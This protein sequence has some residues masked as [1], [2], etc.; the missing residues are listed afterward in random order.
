MRIHSKN[1]SN[2]FKKVKKKFS[3]KRLL[4]SFIILIGLI[5]FGFANILYGAYLNKTGQTS[6]LRMF[7]IRSYERDFSYIPNTF[8]STV[9]PIEDISIDIKFKNWQKIKFIREKALAGQ[10]IDRQKREEVPAKIR[11]KNDVFKASISIT[12]QTNEHIKHPTRWSF[13]VKIK[14]DKTVNGA[15]KFAIIYPSARGYLTDWTAFKLL[16]SQGL[17]GIKN[18][19]VNVTINGKTIGLYYFEERFGDKLIDN[20]KRPEGFIFRLD[21]D[22][23]VYQANKIQK[24][25]EIAAQLIQLKKLLHLL[26]TDKISIEKVFDLE[27]FATLFVISDIM[28]QKHAL[29]RGNM[30]LYYNPVT[31][32]IEPIGR[33]W[34]YLRA[35]E[36]TELALAIEE[37]NEKV[38]YHIDLHEDPVLSKMMNS[39]IF[40]REYVKKAH[41]LSK[42]NYIDSILNNNKADFD[43][44]MNKIHKQNPF[45][46]YPLDLLHEN[47]EYMRLKL[48]PYPL[49]PRIDVF[50]NNISNDS[51][52]LFVKN[53]TFFNIHIDS[54]EYNQKVFSLEKN[55]LLEANYKTSNNLQRL[56]FHSS[57]SINVSTFSSDSLVVYYNVSGLESVEKAIV[58]PKLMSDNDY[59]EVH[60]TKQSPNFNDFSFLRV[61]NKNKTIT[62]P[63]VNCNIT[64][65]LIVPEDYTLI[66]RAGC[67]IDLTNS[68][69]IIS[70]SPLL[71]FGKENQPIEITSSDKSGQGIIV[72]NSRKNSELSYTN[73]TF[74][75][76]ISNDYW[77]LESPIIFYESPFSLSNCVFKNNISGS[78]YL[79][80]IRTKFNI[81]N[82]AFENLKNGAFSASYA[83]GKL[84]TLRFQAIPKDAINVSDSKLEIIE[85]NITDF[86]GIGINASN[87]SKLICNNITLVG[88]EISVASENNTSIIINGLKISSS[89]LGFKVSQERPGAQPSVIKAIKVNLNNV[90]NEFLV[91]EG[92]LLTIDNRVRR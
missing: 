30:R 31:N 16:E 18:D 60:K 61:D 64:K 85:N 17:I 70:Y 86:K 8:K 1:D 37:P 84:D 44:L 4:L 68:A 48:H 66:A 79:K 71:F 83:E 58:F 14:D 12:G 3:G 72:F 27:K 36:R 80:A 32:L 5:L 24:K 43:L 51:T 59:L 40:K 33:E 67:T 92:S 13:L 50:F 57:N 90:K 45:Y 19:F 73:F 52:H 62:F 10:G 15:N 54:I 49:A 34:G 47:Q 88:G 56:S 29:F 75:S 26:L 42:S 28:N 63:A 91:N 53:N 76:K 55:N 87:N 41:I 38:P 69:K 11:Y 65:D 7:V 35:A 20:N 89:K 77:K 25:P 46:K 6:V 78:Y 23:K 9:T 2:Y 82:T 74:L 81:N 21:G 22:L 39:Y